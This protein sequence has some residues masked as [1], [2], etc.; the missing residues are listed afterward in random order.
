MACAWWLGLVVRPGL[1]GKLP[2]GGAVPVT[3]WSVWLSAPW[4]VP[5]TGLQVWLSAPWVVLVTGLQVWLSVP[6]VV[7]ALLPVGQREGLD[8]ALH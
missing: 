2:G 7:L 3:G 6:W 1:V 4:V 5:A 8:P